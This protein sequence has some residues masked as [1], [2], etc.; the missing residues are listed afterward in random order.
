MLRFFSFGVRMQSH[1][2]HFR[3]FNPL[4][5]LFQFLHAIRHLQGVVSLSMHIIRC[6][7]GCHVA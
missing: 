1:L 4:L 3:T 6:L 5:S 2:T 7:H